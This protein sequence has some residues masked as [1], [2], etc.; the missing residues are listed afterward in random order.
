MSDSFFYLL[1]IVIAQIIDTK[2]LTAYTNIIQI[3]FGSL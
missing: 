2:N 1:K 3:I